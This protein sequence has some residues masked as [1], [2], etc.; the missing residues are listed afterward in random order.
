[1]AKCKKKR[2]LITFQE[3]TSIRD[4]HVERSLDKLFGKELRRNI[5]FDEWKKA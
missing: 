2:R 1:M 4:G 5:R 3:R